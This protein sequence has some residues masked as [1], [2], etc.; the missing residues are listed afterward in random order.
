REQVVIRRLRMPCETLLVQVIGLRPQLI[1]VALELRCAQG[2]TTHRPIAPVTSAVFEVGLIVGGAGKEGLPREVLRLLS[3]AGTVPIN[4]GSEELLVA[5]A[6]GLVP[7][8]Q[9]RELNQPRTLHL[10]VTVLVADGDW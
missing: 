8:V 7:A 3:V 4:F 10:L 2:S 6:L 9:L 1:P 5:L